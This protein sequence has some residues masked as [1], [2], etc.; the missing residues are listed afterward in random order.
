[1]T[2]PNKPGPKSAQV[3]EPRADQ[4]EPNVATVTPKT[5]ESKPEEAAAPAT[6]KLGTLDPFLAEFHVQVGERDYVLNYKGTEVAEEDEAAVRTSA[7]A[8]GVKVRKIRQ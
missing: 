4:P 2:S 5:E 6:V 3:V 1:M 7:I 8:S